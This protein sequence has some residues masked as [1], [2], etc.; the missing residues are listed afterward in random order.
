MVFGLIPC[1]SLYSICILLLLF[2]SVIAF[3]M[4]SVN[5]SAYIITFPSTFLAARPIV[6]IN[7]LSERKNPS[8][9]ASKIATKDTSGKSNPSLNRLIPTKTSNS[10]NL[11]SRIISILSSAFVSEC[12]YLT[13]ISIPCK[14]FVKSSAIFLVNVVTNT[15]SCFSVLIFICSIKL[16]IWFSTGLTSICGSNSPVGLIICSTVCSE[17]CFSYSAGVALTKTH[18]LI[19]SSNS[20]NFNGLLS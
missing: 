10:P 3:S 18:W 11:K 14:Y 20:G 4:L 6:C 16:S 2:V 19:L 5:S 7:D 15:L 17:C 8:L 12:I 13:L 9:S 1:F